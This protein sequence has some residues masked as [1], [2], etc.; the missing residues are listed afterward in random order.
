VEAMINKTNM[1][2]IT[3]LSHQKY[4]NIVKGAIKGFVIVGGREGIMYSGFAIRQKE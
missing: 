1:R 2:L 4:F 3:W